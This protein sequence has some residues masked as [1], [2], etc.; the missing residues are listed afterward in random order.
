MLAGV[1]FPDVTLPALQMATLL[2]GL[3]SVPT[4]AWR[5][6]LFLKYTIPIGLGPH[7]YSL[8]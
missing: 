3:A 4:H 1:V 8:I 2:H 6:F 7:P 5:L